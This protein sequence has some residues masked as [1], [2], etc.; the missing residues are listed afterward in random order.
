MSYR[1]PHPRFVRTTLALAVYGALAMPA[2]AVGSS[3]EDR[4][5]ALEARLAQIESENHSLKQQLKQTDQKAD[6]AGEQVEKIASQGITSKASWADATQ[7]GGYG[8]LHL[9]QL[10]ND[11]PGGADKKEM[12]F[13][14]FVIF[15]GHQFNDRLR[16]FSELEVEHN[17]VEGG[18][19]AVELEQA[20]LD[21]MLTDNLS[22][23]AGNFLIP[24]GILNETHEP[25]TF[26]GVER[27]PVENKI[28]PTT[29]WEGGVGLTARLGNGFT[30]DGAVTTGM[31]ADA[32][33]KYAVRAARQA[34]REGTQAKNPAY[35]A[36][37]KW[38]GLPG[39]ELAGTVQY[40]SDVTQGNDATA[41]GAKLLE[42]H[43]IVNQGRFG[44]RALYAGW[45]LDG[46]G[47]KAVGA[48]RQNGWYVE[49]SFK[50]NDAWGLF[51]RYNRW[52]NQAGGG[53]G[54]D[55]SYRQFDAGVNYWP[56]PDVVVKFDLQ[57]QK[58]P[59]GKDEF[60]GFNVG[61]GYRF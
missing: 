1:L 10:K 40:Q 9:N 7:F 47:P 57:R 51:A 35:T 29:W 53:D 24:A 34:L 23:K 28:I 52:D 58:A 38:A 12:D 6:A 32:A 36:R 13:H 26:Y 39:V 33:D 48:D 49:P 45:R 44:L 56:H 43:A 15:M 21:F 60:N 31:K 19:G 22:V 4:L 41:G 11:K 50:L 54:V 3:V 30:L 20:Y 55:S 37:L 5:K 14:R 8:E 16:F 59:M 17:T 27:N 2:F 25:N 42:T 46:S 61:I 18:K